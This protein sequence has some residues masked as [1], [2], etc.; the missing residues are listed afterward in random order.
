[1]NVL[2]NAVRK[3]VITPT[4]TTTQYPR[5]KKNI[6][7]SFHFGDIV[8]NNKLQFLL[9]L[10]WLGVCI[11]P[12]PFPLFIFLSF[13]CNV[14]LD[15][16]FFLSFSLCLIHRLFYHSFL[17]C[18]VLSSIFLL[19]FFIFFSPL[20]SLSP[21]PYPYCSPSPSHSPSLPVSPIFPPK[22]RMQ[23]KLS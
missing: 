3:P 16:I 7:V 18:Q 8:V 21:S 2:L 9:L 10:F 20:F 22:A 23:G 12:F 1:M 4:S 19:S 11:Y 14:H 17:I 13:G 5:V 15:A 6:Y